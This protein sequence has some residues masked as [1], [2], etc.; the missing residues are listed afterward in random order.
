MATTSKATWE[1]MS[2]K[3]KA[4]G[5]TASIVLGEPRSKMQSG[6][7]AIIPESGRIAET[8]LTQP[9]EI[10]VITLRRYENALAEPPEQIELRLDN[11]RAQIAEDIFGD[12][13][14]GGNVAYALPTEFAWAYGYQTVENT[15]YRLLDLT[16]AYRVDERATF[17][18]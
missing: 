13:D 12:F 14:L 15:Q 7:E 4:M 16:V 11:W 1:N 6:T 3:L 2:S 9:R 18:P 8:V 5:G 10:H 17:T